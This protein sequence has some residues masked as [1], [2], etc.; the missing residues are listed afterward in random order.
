MNHTPPAEL[1]DAV[2]RY[3]VDSSSKGRI[4][5]YSKNVSGSCRPSLA[6]CVYE[7]RF[8]KLLLRKRPITN[9][10]IWRVRNAL[11]NH[12]EIYPA[13]EIQFNF[14]RSPR[15]LQ[16]FGSCWE[17]S[18]FYY[19]YENCIIRGCCC[20]LRCRVDVP[21]RWITLIIVIFS[22]LQDVLASGERTMTR[23]LNH[24]R[25]SRRAIR[26]HS[27]AVTNYREKYF[28]T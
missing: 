18:E 2:S 24:Y 21:L 27:N 25:A 6:Q 19:P 7:I 17:L 16:T 23:E 13:R 20:V 12:L 9:K 22:F 1:N 8:T 15:C 10:E 26:I 11:Q 14:P 28:R 3:W 5:P 4:R